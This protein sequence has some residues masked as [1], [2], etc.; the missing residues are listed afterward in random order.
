M[1]DS[2][3]VNSHH[4]LM[5]N[6][7]LPLQNMFSSIQFYRHV[8]CMFCIMTSKASEQAVRIRYPNQQIMAC[9]SIIYHLRSSSWFTYNQNMDKQHYR[10]CI[11]ESWRWPNS[12]G[13]FYGRVSLAI[14]LFE[15]YDFCEI[16]V[17]LFLIRIPVSI[18]L[19]QSLRFLSWLQE[20][21]YIW[22][23]EV[24]TS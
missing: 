20:A 23:N 18:N 10:C 22:V 6:I 16:N 12:S 4:I 17:F 7:K 1:R 15:I 24:L 3:N 11:S 14:V 8:S 13:S 5:Q 9:F 19:V 2:I 21:C